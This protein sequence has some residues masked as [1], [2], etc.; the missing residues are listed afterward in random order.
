MAAAT[1]LYKMMFLFWIFNPYCFLRISSSQKQNNPKNRLK[2]LDTRL[3]LFPSKVDV[4]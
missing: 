4:I 3:V 1:Y 2:N